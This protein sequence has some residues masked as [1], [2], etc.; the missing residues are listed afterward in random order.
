MILHA[1]LEKIIL[2]KLIGD[3]SIDLALYLIISFLFAR[4]KHSFGN[5]GLLKYPYLLTPDIII[6]PS[7]EAYLGI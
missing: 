5:P 3:V 1:N 6:I 2:T 4:T 7:N